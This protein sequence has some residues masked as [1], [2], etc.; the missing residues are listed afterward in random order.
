M[1]RFLVEIVCLLIVFSSLVFS[2][3]SASGAGT[4]SNLFLR[5]GTSTRVAGLSESFTGLADDEN[6]LFYNPGGIPNIRGG[7]VAL[8]HTEWFQDI[9]VDNIVFART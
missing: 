8:N 3:E 7:V 1:T 4:A 2:Q 9:R 5:F 6:T